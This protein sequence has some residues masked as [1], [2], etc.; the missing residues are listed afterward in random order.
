MCSS[1]RKYP[2][3]PP[4]PIEGNGNSEGRGGG[5]VKKKAIL[6]ARVFSRG[7]V[8]GLQKNRIEYNNSLFKH[9]Q[10]YQEYKKL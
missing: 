3:P 10:I 8:S 6:E 5:G 2:Y 4:A 9:G 7:S 1:S